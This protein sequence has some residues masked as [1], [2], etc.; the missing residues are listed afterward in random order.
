MSILSVQFFVFLVVALVVYYVI[1]ARHQWKGLLLISYA[2]YLFAGVR[3][4]IFILLTSVSTY[5]A[6]LWIGKIN[7]EFEVAVANY[8]GPN[9][10]MTRAEKKEIKAAEDKRKR[11]ILIFTLL[12]NFGILIA[13]KYSNEVK[14]L[15]TFLCSLVGLHYEAPQ[16]SILIP[17]GISYYTF[18][19]MAYVLDLYRRKISPERSLPRLMLFISFF[20]QLVQGPISRFDELAGQLYAPHA[21]D[22]K[23]IRYGVEL[24]AWGFF[25]KLV[26]SDRIAIITR[27]IWDAPEI[28]PGFYLIVAA[29]LST[30]Q[31]YTD[32]SGGIDIARGVAECFGV[33]MPE[34][35]TRPFF[36]KNM[37]DFWQR[38]HITLNNWWRDY[39]FYPLTLS[40]PFARMGKALRKTVSDNLGK[41]FPALVSLIVIRIL[42]SIWHGGSAGSVLAGLYYGIVLALSFYYEPHIKKLTA[43]LRINT[44]CLSWKAFQCARTAIL[45]AAPRLIV[46]SAGFGDAVNYIRC[47]FKTFNPWILFDGSLFKLGVTAHQFNAVICGLVLLFLVGWIQ[48]H[49][50]IVRVE[51]DKQNMVIRGLVYIAFIYSIVLFGAYGSGYDASS[52]TYAL[53]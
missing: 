18:Q 40:K 13:L 4:I 33:D 25:K 48:E 6:G 1:P 30:L 19:S 51:L 32:F 46:Y 22:S 41:K 17:L 36:A 27:T 3:A 16:F 12:L 7:D 2:F 43:K 21:F 42:G 29:I 35:F 37:S 10:K 45:F 49:G 39:I 8:S 20:P 53:T 38:W 23:R 26:L 34:N 50:K 9:P 44:E 47:L 14:A 15:L 11:V 24:M 5:F 31:L 52:F 28:Y